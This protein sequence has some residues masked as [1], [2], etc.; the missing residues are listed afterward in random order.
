[1]FTWS[2]APSYRANIAHTPQI[3]TS[4]DARFCRFI[5]FWREHSV[6]VITEAIWCLSR[7]LRSMFDESQNWQGNACENFGARG[8]EEEGN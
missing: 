3:L 4:S 8:G 6:H 2:L 1:V 7:S 5:V